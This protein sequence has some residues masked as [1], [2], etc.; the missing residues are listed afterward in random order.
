LYTHGLHEIEEF[1]LATNLR[2]LATPRQTL[3]AQLPYYRRVK[4]PGIAGHA[5]MEIHDRD[6]AEF[7]PRSRCAVSQRGVRVS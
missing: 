6:L 7:A 5:V 1:E 2:F 4:A 3:P